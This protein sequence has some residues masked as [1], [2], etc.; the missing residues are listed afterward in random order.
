MKES[1][2]Y[3]TVQPT[4]VGRKTGHDHEKKN[5]V[6]NIIFVQEL[7]FHSSNKSSKSS[8]EVGKSNIDERLY[9]KRMNIPVL[10]SISLAII[11]VLLTLAPD[12]LVLFPGWIYTS[13]LSN[14]FLF[15]GH[16]E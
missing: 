6:D 12:F 8:S 16:C 5:S 13:D 4:V 1:I 10:K 9:T 14:V 2:S 11:V 3:K 7:S 15:Q